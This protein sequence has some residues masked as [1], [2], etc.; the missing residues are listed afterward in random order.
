VETVFR[1][2]MLVCKQCQNEF[3]YTIGQQRQAYEEHGTYQEPDL[4][5]VCEVKLE[6]RGPQDA[7]EPL[8]MAEEAP[9]VTNGYASQTN[10]VSHSSHPNNE[11]A[12]NGPRAQEAWQEES[13]SSSNPSP[14]RPMDYRSGPEHPLHGRGGE[15]FTGHVKWFNDRKGFGFIT[16]DN[17]IEIFV[18]YSGIV[19]E[20][21]KTLKQD[22]RVQ[23]MV[24]DTDKGPQASQVMPLP[25]QPAEREM[26]E[27]PEPGD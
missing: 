11:G 13:T 17:G 20:G 23:V 19:G 26:M 10:G 7:G 22:Q 5:P 9:R 12:T 15:R 4:C 6:R 25:E 2:K 24:E 3:V 8:A 14:N 18:H 21:Y 16:L 27:E 1:D